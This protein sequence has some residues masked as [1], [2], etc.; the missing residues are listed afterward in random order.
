MAA[1]I[2]QQI[3]IVKLLLTHYS[4]DP[5]VMSM[6]DDVSVPYIEFILLYAPQS[7]IIAIMNYCGV[8]SDFKTTDGFSLL[9]Y[10]IMCNCFDVV[11]LL[12]E[13]CSDIDVNVTSDDSLKTPLH[14]YSLSYWTYTNSTIFDTTWCICVCCGQQWVYTI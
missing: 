8:K 6:R 2:A 13:E 7:F 1:T 9:H 4:M 5:Y 11:C 14:L 12:L 10:A 3:D